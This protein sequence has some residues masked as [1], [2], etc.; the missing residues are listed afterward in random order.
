MRVFDTSSL[1]IAL[2]T[3][4]VDLLRNS[5]ALIL[6]KFEFGNLLWKEISLSKSISKHEG[7]VTFKFFL[8]NFNKMRIIN[9]D[10]KKV[11]SLAVSL[12]I[13]FYDASFIQAAIKMKAPLI[14]EDQKLK[15]IASDLVEVASLDD[16]SLEA[17]T[18]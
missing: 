8:K 12:N 9:T 7:L 4:H 3:A 1:Y 2:K 17:P 15:R 11:L 18:N 10:F 13:S 14:T 5:Y 6:S 16:V